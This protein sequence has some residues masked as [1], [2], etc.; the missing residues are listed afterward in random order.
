[1]PFLD[2]IRLNVWEEVSFGGDR[3]DNH[4]ENDFSARLK[5]VWTSYDEYEY[6][7]EEEMR[8]N[9][10]Y[11]EDIGDY[12]HDCYYCNNCDTPFYNTA[13]A[14]QIGENFYCCDC[15]TPL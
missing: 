3:P 6:D 14:V 12:A 11:C 9:C 8:D 13:D 10:I 2:L 1:M 5:C 4:K 15:V 7:S